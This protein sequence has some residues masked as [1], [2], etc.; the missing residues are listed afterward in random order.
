MRRGHAGRAGTAPPR[1]GRRI[2]RPGRRLHWR[3]S[4]GR[5]A[6]GEQR[7][8]GPTWQLLLSPFV[9]GGSVLL[10]VACTTARDSV[11]ALSDCSATRAIM[12]RR[13]LA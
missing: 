5:E 2:R 7:S 11:R 6:W 9:A 10:E 1:S 3:K 13:P 8:Q 4:G 12:P